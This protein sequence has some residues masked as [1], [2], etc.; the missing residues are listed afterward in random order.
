MRIFLFMPLIAALSGCQAYTVGFEQSYCTDVNLSDP[1]DPEIWFVEDGDDLL[2]IRSHAFVSSDWLF[3]PVVEIG[4][5]SVFGRVDFLVEEKWK[6]VGAS[7]ETSCISPTL[8]VSDA[9]GDSFSVEWYEDEAD[10]TPV[11]IGAN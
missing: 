2:I 4:A 7:E 1:G 11:A 9:V 8:R 6:E 3:D 5:R 10:G